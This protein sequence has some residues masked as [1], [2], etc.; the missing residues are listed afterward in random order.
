MNHSLLQFCHVLFVLCFLHS[1][2]SFS[3]QVSGGRGIN[4]ALYAE[5]VAGKEGK[6]T[7]VVKGMK[8]ILRLGRN[9]QP[10]AEYIKPKGGQ[11]ELAK[12]YAKIEDVE[13]R[14]FQILVDLG[15]VVENK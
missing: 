15:L 13:E 4:S 12:K 1:A 3:V 11:N 9:E 2:S 5:G 14:A 6:A 7:R 10:K 8:K